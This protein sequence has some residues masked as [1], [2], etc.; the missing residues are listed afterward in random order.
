MLKKIMIPILLVIS[1]VFGVGLLSS[2]TYAA[3]SRSDILKKWTFAGYRQCVTNDKAINTS[4]DSK[5]GN[6]KVAD[7]VMKKNKGTVYLPSYSFGHS[8]SGGSVNCY[9]LFNG[10]NGL[11]GVVSYVGVG[12][13]KWSNPTATKDLLVNNLKY[14]FLSTGNN[15][16]NINAMVKTKVAAIGYSG[17]FESERHEAKIEEIGAN[18]YKANSS[19]TGLAVTTNDSK[20]TISRN[21]LEGCSI[22]EPIVVSFGT[23]GFEGFATR[24]SRALAGVTWQCSGTN[25]ALT[26][27][28]FSRGSVVTGQ[29]GTYKY[30]PSQTNVTDEAIKAMT[31]MNGGNLTLNKNERFVLYS[32]YIEKTVAAENGKID[33]SEEPETGDNYTTVKLKSEGKIKECSVSFNQKKPKDIWVY[34]LK[35]NVGIKPINM[36]EV[37][38]W[39]NAKADS[40]DL[41]EVSSIDSSEAIGDGVKATCAN[42]GAAE[43]L[44]WVLCPVLTF[45]SNAAKDAYNNY[46]EP[47]LRVEPTL[48]QD[49][50]S[51][52]RGTE[53]AWRV[54]QGIANT[55]FIILLLVVIFSQLT[56]VGIDN[57]GIKKIL[58]KLIIAAV[59]INLS[60]LICQVFVDLSNILG[61]S[62]Q[63]LF[64][65]LSE[66]IKNDIPPNLGIDGLGD[67][68]SS[69]GTTAITGLAVLFL[70]ALEIWSVAQAGGWQ[71]ILLA[72]LVAALSVAVAIFFLFLLLAAREA[73]IVVLTVISPLAFACFILPNTK[74]LF[75]KWLKIGWGLLLVYP[76]CGI[77][78]GGGNFVSVLMLSAGAAANN[79]FFSAFMAMVVGVVPIFFIP[80]VLKNSFSAL[81]SLGA[82]ISGMGKTLGNRWGGRLDRT[83]QNSQMYKSSRAGSMER[84]NLRMAGY[85]RDANGN[86]VKRKPSRFATV[87]RMRHAAHGGDRGEEMAMAQVLADREAQ[88]KREDLRMGTGFAAGLAGIEAKAD[89]QA[90]ANA[91]ALLSNG[92]A[93]VDGRAVNTSDASS[94]GTYHMDALRRYGEAQNDRERSNIM[95]E[96]K[97]AQNLMSKTDA[98]RS[99]VQ[100]NFEQAISEGGSVTKG[101]SGAASH[102]SSNYG[103]LYK[104]KNRGANAMI[105]DLATAGMTE[106]GDLAIGSTA[107][108]NSIAGK[109]AQGTYDAMGANKYTQE[110]LAN[111]DIQ[112]LRK[113]ANMVESGSMSSADMQQIQTTASKALQMYEEGKLSMQPEVETYMRRIAGGVSTNA[114]GT[115]GGAGGTTAGG[116]G[117]G[118][119][120]VPG[121]ARENETFDIH[122]QSNHVN[123]VEDYLEHQMGSENYN[124]QNNPNR[125]VPPRN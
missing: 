23:D 111:A 13:A 31:G 91:E 18:K 55:L 99:Q 52:G 120:P 5:S 123:G 124:R 39:L 7:S 9:Q 4:I 98:G 65:G 93:M 101:L 67:V 83:A 78:I 80:T 37:I 87:N 54:F 48:F 40:V 103:D 11:S 84:K 90:V 56:G 92:K 72:L 107:D 125:G 121:A 34:T 79:G 41:N 88:R 77:L 15:Y 47:A 110:S 75:D 74:K 30:Y 3:V 70:L 59:L 86:I 119:T 69:I 19:W 102:L 58:P 57:Y 118:G 20:L 35:K 16:F 46:V 29:D 95:A 53:D 45:L 63:A 26:E 49:T 112:A 81:G 36:E 96:I 51:G 12:D 32:D 64:D 25:G 27:Y 68:G 76:I 33:C 109:L 108:D 43:S 2:N 38:T 114:G 66:P 62:F 104:S 50:T 8:V 122:N 61:N 106:N 94:L 21:F 100:S 73:A 89:S 24:V 117:A 60:Y 82:K 14:T 44:G 6:G 115:T 85:K 105:G 71:A 10:V 113:M 116:A 28:S 1:C 42:T 97:A 22:Y 17:E